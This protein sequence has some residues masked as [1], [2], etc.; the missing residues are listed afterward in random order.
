MDDFTFARVVHLVAVL[1]WIGGVAF[2]TMVI[3]PTMR[4]Y[5]AAE[6]RLFAFHAIEDG[7]AW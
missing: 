5:E 2:F 6:R 1:L 7:F 3:M 4:K